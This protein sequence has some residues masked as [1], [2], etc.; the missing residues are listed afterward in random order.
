LPVERGA[1]QLILAG[2]ARQCAQLLPE[3]PFERLFVFGQT[4][5]QPSTSAQVAP[6]VPA[7]DHAICNQMA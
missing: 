6:P 5:R 1:R 2:S 7:L 3:A 4:L